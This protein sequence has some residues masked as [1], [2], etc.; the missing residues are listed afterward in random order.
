LAIEESDYRP[1]GLLRAQGDRPSHCAAE[2]D[3]EL[4]SLS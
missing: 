1:R 3:Y 4:A 2:K